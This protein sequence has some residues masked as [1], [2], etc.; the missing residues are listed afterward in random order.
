MI[1]GIAVDLDLVPYGVAYILHHM[2][3]AEQVCCGLIFQKDI[4]R[5]NCLPSSPLYQHSFHKLEVPYAVVSVLFVSIDMYFYF[6][7]LIST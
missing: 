2:G 3:V 6:F 4:S 5:I 7:I 1:P